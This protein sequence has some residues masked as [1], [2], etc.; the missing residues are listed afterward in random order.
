MAI[1]TATITVYRGEDVDLPFTHTGAITGWTIVLSVRG[2]SGVVLSK[3]ATP[4]DA[5][6]GTYKFPLV[7]TDTDSL[8]PGTYTYD[9]WRTDADSERVLALGSFVLIAGARVTT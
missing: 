2:V 1:G 5:G 4:V 6:A 7:D 8:R 9:V 3:S